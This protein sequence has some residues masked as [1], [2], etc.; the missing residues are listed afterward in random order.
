MIFL[1]SFRGHEVTSIQLIKSSSASEDTM[2]DATYLSLMNR[3]VEFASKTP[4]ES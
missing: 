3:A 1:F 4:S 2:I